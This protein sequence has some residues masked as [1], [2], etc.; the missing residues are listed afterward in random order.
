MDTTLLVVELLIAGTQVS[1]WLFMLILTFF[2]YSWIQIQGVADWQNIAV[3]LFLAFSYSLGVVF[4]RFADFVFEPWNRRLKNKIIPNP[5]F[6]I[7]VMRFEIGKD[8]ESLHHQ[9]EYTRS[10]MRIARAS[11]INMGLIAVSAIAFVLARVQ[12]ISNSDK[13][14]LCIALLVTGAC[15]VSLCVYAWRNLMETYLELVKINYDKL[16]SVTW[17]C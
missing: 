8:N 12:G 13:I 1:V 16:K 17:H 4:D 3:V 11:A 10:R 6:P 14:G 2:G 5:P 7:V 9:F 15:L